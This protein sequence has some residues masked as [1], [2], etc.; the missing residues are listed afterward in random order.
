MNFDGVDV[1]I[2]DFPNEYTMLMDFVEWFDDID[3]DILLAWGMG[4]Y[5]LPTLY[6]R[7]ESTGIGAD[8]LSPSSLGKNRHVDAPS[9][10][11]KYRYNWTAQPIKGRIVVSLDRIS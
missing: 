4:F 10:Y 3:P 5:D 1:E 2:R 11:R 6:A 8:K 7:L 9:Q